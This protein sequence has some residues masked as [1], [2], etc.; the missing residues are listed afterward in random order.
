MNRYV[1]TGWSASSGTHTVTG[2]GF[3]VNAPYT[4][5]FRNISADDRAPEYVI[6]PGKTAP[7]VDKE[8]LLEVLNGA[9]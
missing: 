7:K 4:I 6:I 3:T 1:Y 9:L 5:A 2:S 8:Q